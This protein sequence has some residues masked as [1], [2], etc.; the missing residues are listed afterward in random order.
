MRP[1]DGQPILTA[2]QM[3][4]AEVKAAPDP[5]S[6][7]LLMERAGAGVA[8][9]IRR[10]AAGAHVLVLCG[11]G[12]N[13]GD[14]YVAARV[15]R[16]QGVP[17]R[18]AASGPPRTDLAKRAHASW[19]AAV[20]PLDD[21]VG[22]PVR[23]APILVDALFGTGSIRPIGWDIMEPFGKLAEAA[24]LLIAVDLPSGLDAN[25]YGYFLEPF[26][27]SPSPQLTLAL[28]ALKPAHTNPSA[29][30]N[31]GEV[32]LIDLGLDLKNPLIRTVQ[33]PQIGVLHHQLNKYSRG[34]VAVIAGEMPGAAILAATAAQR[35]GAGYVAL[36]GEASGGPAS[37][38]HRP[39]T[40]A[41]LL[42]ERIDV[43]VIGPGLGRSDW[44]R[45]WTTWLVEKTRTT[46]VIDADALALFDPRHLRI[47]SGPVFLTPHAG[48]MLAME[49]RLG[50]ELDW[51]VDRFTR[52]MML[53]QT[54]AP[55]GHFVLI[56]K[57]STTVMTSHHG[58]RV[59]PRGDPWLSTAG[60]GDV[61]AGVVAAM[62]AAYGKVGGSILDAAEAAVWLHGQAA[63]I[64]GPGFIADDLA[65]ALSSARGSL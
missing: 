21:D 34:M 47:R 31:C 59:S 25:G 30:L 20:E 16:E 32:R 29:I 41:A 50:I 28:G 14:G 5:E 15:L 54:I 3:R 38:V 11:P 46:L 64:A 6:L 12:N 35:A 43:I 7:Y 33:R 62:A 51:E 27:T 65:F 1:I 9:V 39:L 52:S 63:R 4:A 10:V 44:A 36:F 48:E 42:D 55:N 13:G 45:Q 18:V 49:K 40:E 19:G 8:D 26:V 22:E 57:G 17:V 58:V 24:R 61:L 23:P 2:A 37:L 56:E 53:H 60:T